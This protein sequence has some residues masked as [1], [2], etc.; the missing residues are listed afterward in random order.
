MYIAYHAIK[1]MM[2]IDR[3]KEENEQKRLDKLIRRP[4]VE[5]PEPEQVEEEV[6]PKKLTYAQQLSASKKK[7]EVV[8]EIIPR[9]TDED[10][11]DLDQ[12][13]RYWILVNYF[14]DDDE[15]KIS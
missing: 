7:V 8:E 3:T 4:P 12:Y 1:K 6:K 5:E 2:L 10:R 11:K 13:G 14:K 9:A 15:E